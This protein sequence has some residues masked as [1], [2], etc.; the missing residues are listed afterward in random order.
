[1][2]TITLAN[3][4]LLGLY[5]AFLIGLLLFSRSGSTDDRLATAYIVLLFIPLGIL[6]AINLLPFQF[7]RIAVLVL[8]VTPPVTALLMLITSPIIGKWKTATWARES[9]ELADGSYYFKDD[10]RRKLAMSIVALDAEQ[11]A[12]DM[13]QPI[14]TLNQTAHEQVTLLDFAAM[15]GLE[16]D[17]ARLIACLEVLL[18]NGAKIDNGDP[19]H[20][21]TH[22]LVRGY[23]PALLKW[24]LENGADANARTAGKGIPLLFD[25]VCG[26]NSEPARLQK[27]ERV[28]ML[29]EHGADPNAKIPKADELT[30]ESSILLTAADL[31]LWMICDM[32]IEA[33]ADIHYQTP[34]GSTI[35]SSVGYQIKN[36]HSWGKTPPDD[37]IKLAQR[38]NLPVAS[39]TPQ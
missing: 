32:L 36:H 15:Q 31:E 1:M 35:A 22:F 20:T 4:C 9:A 33:G 25:V 18:K 3:W 14:P 38:L 10:Q 5:T 37:L 21:P 19:A 7:T 26:E 34:G 16:A 27:A 29:L 39:G 28:R 24:F 11:L 12:E 2:K 6:A 8:C 13:K 17:T 23:S 30:L